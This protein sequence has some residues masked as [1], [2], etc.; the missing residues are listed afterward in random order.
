MTYQLRHIDNRIH[1]ILTKTARG[2]DDIQNYATSQANKESV[3]KYENAL[4]Q[5]TSN[6]KKDVNDQLDNL[7]DDITSKRPSSN[8]PN[9]E[10]MLEKYREYLVHANDGIESM[11][12]MFAK[13][14]SKLY[15]V[16]KKIVKWIVDHLPEII[17]A[18]V[19]IFASII[20]PLLGIM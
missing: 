12:G 16:V 17:S 19:T 9:Y 6:L 13:L 7:H 4:V 20:L 10:Q 1:D 8:D 14:F 18:I 15:E 11:K 5:R 2:V 3:E